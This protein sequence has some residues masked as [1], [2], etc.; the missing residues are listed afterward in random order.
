MSE[1]GLISRGVGSAG[2]ISSGLFLWIL[3]VRVF[4]CHSISNQVYIGGCMDLCKVICR[5]AKVG[6]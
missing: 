6:V 2:V 5:E 1:R 3:K 4:V